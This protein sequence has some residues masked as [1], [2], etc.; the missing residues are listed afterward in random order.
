MST[1]ISS[2]RHL[3]ATQPV[4]PATHEAAIETALHAVSPEE[5]SQFHSLFESLQSNTGPLFSLNTSPSFDVIPPAEAYESRSHEK[6]AS[7]SESTSQT[8][9]H[10]L[11]SKTNHFQRQYPQVAEALAKKE[12][13]TQTFISNMLGTDFAA[14]NM[15]DFLGREMC[16]EDMLM[17]VMMNIVKNEE[18]KL[19]EELRR[20]EKNNT[21]LQT[22]LNERARD[23]GGIA[24][25]AIG[26]FFG[27]VPGA[28]VGQ[29]IGDRLAGSAIGQTPESKQ[30]QM[31]KITKMVNDLSTMFSL[32]SNTIKTNGDTQK[33]IARKISA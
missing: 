29:E 28:A 14:G 11:Q 26:G 1:P 8:P 5:L 22:A 27:G 3:P 7:Y 4:I 15:A 24:G 16:Y 13:Q 21:G 20:V 30:L 25:G 12:I 19:T 18:K 10:T 23:V 6:S 9:R 32:L 31:Q 33:E 17:H 2:H